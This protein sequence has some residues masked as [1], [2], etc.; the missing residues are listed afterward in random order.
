MNKTNFIISNRDRRYKVNES[1]FKNIV[2]ESVKKLIREVGEKHRF[3]KGAY[4]LAMDAAKKARSLGRHDQA[5]NLTAHAARYFNDK[6]GTDG[7]EMDDFGRLKHTSDLGRQ[8]MYKPG[9]KIRSLEKNTDSLGGQQAFYDACDDNERIIRAARTAK[10]YPRKRMTGGLE[11]IDAV[12]SQLNTE[13]INRI[14]KK[15]VSKVLNEAFKSPKLD[16]MARQ[17][18]GIDK[19]GYG[20]LN[21]YELPISELTDDM[22]GDEAQKL[23]HYGNANNAV[24]FKDGTSVP[25]TDRR[26]ALKLQQDFDA[27]ADATGRY[28]NLRDGAKKFYPQTEKGKWARSTRNDIAYSKSLRGQQTPEFTGPDADYRAK[29]WNGKVKR[30]SDN[31]QK[32]RGNVRDVY[33]GEDEYRY[34]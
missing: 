9:S 7:F 3:G 16:A 24:N 25:I 14:V 20:Y 15:S 32:R 1:Q 23:S 5:D 17:H 11:A 27:N 21:G 2:K 10:A 13:S 8:T 31:E 12:D 28:D 33:N 29:E 19:R 26:A 18:G 22:I 4:G 30:W 34:Y 6:Y